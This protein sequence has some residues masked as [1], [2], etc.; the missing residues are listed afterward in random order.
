MIFVCKTITRLTVEVNKNVKLQN[1]IM[2]YTS[3]YSTLGWFS[4]VE[5]VMCVT[6]VTC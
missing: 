6:N 1:E 3:T 2:L 5:I 4:V